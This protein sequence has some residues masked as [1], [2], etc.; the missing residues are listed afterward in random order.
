M[1]IVLFLKTLCYVSLIKW[2]CHGIVFSKLNAV[3]CRTFLATRAE[4]FKEKKSFLF[5]LN[6]KSFWWLKKMAFSSYYISHELS[7]NNFQCY[8][9]S[10]FLLQLMVHI[11]PSTERYNNE[12]GFFICPNAGLEVLYLFGRCFA[13]RCNSGHWLFNNRSCARPSWWFTKNI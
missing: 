7:I 8:F 1:S 2:H 12:T 11:G 4:R 10:A 13:K 3:P 9:P 6:K 5:A